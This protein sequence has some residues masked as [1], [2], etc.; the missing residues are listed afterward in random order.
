MTGA[1][2]MAL[3]VR[4]FRADRVDELARRYGLVERQRALDVI[5]FVV[6][7]ILSGGTHD[8]G[9]QYDVLRTYLE[10][11]ARRVTRGAFYS[12]FNEP[13]EGLLMTLLAD[14][15]AEGAAVPSI[16]PG[17]L[18]GVS[19]WR[20]VD[21][22]TIKL[23][24]ALLSE[25]PGTGDY[26]AGKIHK[27]WSVGRG[28]LV[29]FHLSPAREHDN[30]HLTVDEARR[31][32][33]LLV[34]LGYASFDLLRRCKAHDVRYVIR[35]KE[36]WKPRV[37]RIVRGALPADILKTGDLD[38]LLGD[39]VLL[40]DG[41]AIDA[42]VTVG[43]GESAVASRLV[44]VPTPKGYC[45]FLTNV[46]RRTHGPLQIGDIYRARWEIELDNKVDKTGARIDEITAR[47]PTSVRILLL[48]SL[49]NTTLARIIV[50]REK[51]SILAAK[52]DPSDPAKKPPLHATQVVR[53]MRVSHSAVLA[54]LSGVVPDKFEWNRI[55]GNIRSLGHDPN[56]RRRPSVLDVIQGLTA[57]PDRRRASKKASS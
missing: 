21:S 2:L 1:E 52:A 34:D 41:H 51:A 22:T 50:Q 17:I 18:A 57:P 8:G 40:R 13:L 35:L 24:K 45:F 25:W 10:N 53:A 4:V 39:H 38:I 30:P 26:A 7:L 43:R 32:T 28:N 15:I 47:K 44:G 11:G 42:D 12:W 49:L 36:S 46:P 6:S 20:I 31:G 37:D 29:T 19:D 27:E 55:M 16:L 54:V 9:R 5:G 23:D 3:F 14:A 56:W 48:A 33:G